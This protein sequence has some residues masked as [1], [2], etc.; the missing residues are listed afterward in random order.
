MI[1]PTGRYDWRAYWPVQ[2]EVVDVPGDHF[3]VLEQH[4]PTTADA[5]RQWIEKREQ[6]WS[7][8]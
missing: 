4:T 1:D 6:E 2:H 3:T 7:T 5:V 8:R